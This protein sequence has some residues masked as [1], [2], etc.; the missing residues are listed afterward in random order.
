MHG[1]PG[2]NDGIH[3]LTDRINNDLYLGLSGSFRSIC[4][5]SIS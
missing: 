4:L 2:W 1:I 5:G 3:M